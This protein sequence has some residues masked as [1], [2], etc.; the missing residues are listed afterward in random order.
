MNNDLIDR[1][2]YAV[3]KRMAPKLREDVKQELSGLIEDLL[4]ERCGAS[5]PTEKDIRV[6]LTELGGP[7]EM[8]EKYDER[9][10]KT[11]L[12]QPYY[13]LWLRVLMIVLPCVVLGMTVSSGI[14]FFAEGQP[15]YVS[16]A[17]WAGMVWSAGLQAFA[18]VTLLFIFFSRRGIRLEEPYNFDDL[19]PVPKG[20]TFSRGGC[21]AAIGF[22]LFFMVWFLCFPQY[23]IIF[24]GP[25]GVIPL[26]DVE[27][28]RGS[29]YLI[30]ALG[31][32]GIAREVVRLR[33]G[34]YTRRVL[35]STLAANGGQAV[36]AAIWL[37][38]ATQIS[39]E[40]SA[41]VEKLF[42][43][44]DAFAIFFQKFNYFLLGI[45]LVALVM[46][47]VETVYR[48]MKEG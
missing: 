37:A 21:W 19:P 32:L 1:Y 26:F 7:R 3:T 5:A 35:V 8:Y 48:T 40:G 31:L 4:E 45:I 18:L 41:W 43:E 24:A 27:T 17:S 9:S 33:E 15:W 30:L 22:S 13:D 20:K 14:L 29:G 16:L 38:G 28:L 25:E 2:L 11:L 44:N 39:Q 46:D 47:T 36:I 34:R 12:S 10:G 23:V 6:V 42:R